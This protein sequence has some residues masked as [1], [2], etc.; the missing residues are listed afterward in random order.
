MLANI[1]LQKFNFQTWIMAP[2]IFPVTIE[3]HYGKPIFVTREDLKDDQKSRFKLS[4]IIISM[5]ELGN[6]R[7]IVEAHLRTTHQIH[8][9]PRFLELNKDEHNKAEKLKIAILVNS[10]ENELILDVFSD[11]YDSA[12]DNGFECKFFIFSG[13]VI[14]LNIN[15]RNILENEGLDSLKNYKPDLVFAEAHSNSLDKLDVQIEHL[16]ALKNEIKFKFFLIS[17]DIWREYDINCIKKWS[18]VYDLLVH[19][20]RQSVDFFQIKNEFWWPYFGH[21][22]AKSLDLQ[23][24]NEKSDVIFSGN[25]NFPQRRFWLYSC[26][27][28]AKSHK[29]KLI[30]QSLNYGSGRFKPRAIYLNEL[31]TSKACLNHT[32]KKTGFTLVTFRTFDVV[33]SGRILL[34]QEDENSRPLRDFLIPYKHYIPFTSLEELEVIFQIMK[35]KPHLIEDIGKNGKVFFEDNYSSAYL[36]QI[37][38]R[39]FKSLA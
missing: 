21:T 36:W 27:Q 19:L 11:L 15:S 22:K 30:I 6:L 16:A 10:S 24:K 12:I 28:I 35:E 8:S 26:I 2:I 14:N 29:I 4:E 25:L 7:Q 1:D 13:E 39:K 31:M 9:T 23:S 33:N 32:W 37:L 34:Q 3:I 18:A 38:I 20:D 5:K 17:I